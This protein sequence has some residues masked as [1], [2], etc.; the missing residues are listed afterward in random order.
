[1]KEYWRFTADTFLLILLTGFAL[2]SSRSP[3]RADKTISPRSSDEQRA[4][5]SLVFSTY[6]GGS[7]QDSIRDVAT[8]REGNIYITGGTESSDFPT[9]P[10]AYDT[11][12]NGWHNVFVTKF[13]PEGNLLWSTFLGGPNYDRAYAIEVDRLDY[14]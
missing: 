13:H 1:M 10:G 7:R 5:P 11:T 12:F 14:T 6:I 3:L 2:L 9:T 8:D 4:T